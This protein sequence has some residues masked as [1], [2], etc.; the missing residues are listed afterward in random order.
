ML[1]METGFSVL[2]LLL[3][4]Q[5]IVILDKSFYFLLFA[6]VTELQHNGCEESSFITPCIQVTHRLRSHLGIGHCPGKSSCGVRP[7]W[8]EQILNLHFPTSEALSP[9]YHN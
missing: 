5:K 9:L 4:S 7:I 1:H 6:A 2:T 8:L 3:V